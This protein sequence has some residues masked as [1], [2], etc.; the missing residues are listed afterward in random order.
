MIL[1]TMTTGSAGND[2]DLVAQFRDDQLMHGY[3][4]APGQQGAGQQWA[5]MVQA[6][7]GTAMGSSRPRLRGVLIAIVAALVLV[8]ALI[9][10]LVLAG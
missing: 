8:A 3:S 6:T 5:T 1:V 9:L 7:A 4:E 10:A 2:D